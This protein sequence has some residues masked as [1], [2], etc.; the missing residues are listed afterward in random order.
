[1][2]RLAVRIVGASIA[3]TVAG[4]VLASS[5][6]GATGQITRADATADW[7]QGSVAGS[8]AGLD[9]A[10]FEIFSW[11]RAYVVP[12]GAVCTGI[13]VYD[14]KP[15]DDFKV[16]WESS[17]GDQNPSFDLPEVT[18]NRGISPRVCLYSVYKANYWLPGVHYRTLL[19]SRLFT[20]PPP[21][22]PPTQG[23]P[24]PT[25]V[26]LSRPTALSKAKS[27]LEKRFGKAYRRGQRKRLRCSKQ[28]STRYLCRF[29]FRYGKGHQ[30]GTVTVARK[31]NGSVTTKIKRR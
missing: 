26:S 22:R 30:A 16:V 13:E 4:V 7:S 8:V 19:A 12:N 11:A 2:K 6:L 24:V 18:L 17:S 15:P 31:P 21:P 28:T 23:M 10:S 3:S 9:P 25:V 5:A 27:A 14:P 20:A 29:S 1:M